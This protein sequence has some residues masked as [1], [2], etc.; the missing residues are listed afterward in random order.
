[1]NMQI[2]ILFINSIKFELDMGE[3]AIVIATQQ[4]SMG[5]L[6]C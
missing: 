3:D 6:T 2:T 4:I 1:M 5:M